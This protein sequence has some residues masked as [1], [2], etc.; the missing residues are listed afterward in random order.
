MGTVGLSFGS[1]FSGQGFNVSST[2]SEI[3]ANMSGVETPWTSQITTIG[4][5]DTVL[6]SLGTILS[7]LSTDMSSLTDVTGV[8]SQK[9]GS[10]SNTTALQLTA[11]DNTAV[12]G[13]H[14]VVINKLAT[15]SSGVLTEVSSASATLTGSIVIQVGSASAQTVTL[16]SSDN[17]LTGLATA[18]NTAGIGVTASVLTDSSG[19]RLSIV[20]GT[21]GLPGE[22]N[23]N[24]SISTAPATGSPV[25]LS[26][27]EAVPGADGSIVVD[28]VTL[29]TSSN[30]VNNLIPGVTFQLLA[31]TPADSNGNVSPVQV[32]IANYNSGVESTLNSLVTDYNSLISAINT[33]EGNDSSGNAEPLYGSP[34]LS[35]LQQDILNGMVN[36]NPN[37]Y[38]DAVS[39]SSYGQLSGSVVLQVGSGPGYTFVTGTGTNTTNTI[40]TGAGSSANTISGL[41]AAINANASKGVPL[42]ATVTA[43]S[44]STASGA[45]LTSID[46]LNDTL[47]GS[48]SIGVGGGTV[49]NVVIGYPPQIPAANTLYTNTGPMTAS[50]LATFISSNSLGV[51]AFVNDGSNGSGTLTLTSLTAGSAGT[52]TVNSGLSASGIGLSAGVVTS[53]GQST[54]TMVSDTAGASGVPTVTSSLTSL[55]P[56]TLS[57]VDNGTTAT[58]ASGSLGSV[59]NLTDH[60]SG[61]V[62]IQV[63]TAAPQTI[64]LSSN[65]TLQGLSDAIQHANLGVNAVVETV[66]GESSIQLYSTI[67]GTAGALTVTPSLVDLSN[68]LSTHVA[69]NFSSDLTSMT[70][71]GISVNNDG[72]LSLDAA[73]LDSV[74]NADFSGVQGLFQNA[75]SWGT[76]FASTLNNAGTSSPT[77]VLSLGLDSNSSIESTL[78]ADISRENLLISSQ[79]KSLTAELNSA[80]EVLQMIPSQLSQVNELYSAITGY[81]Q[82]SS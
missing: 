41:A 63:G 28:G 25:A 26:Y 77:G 52:L 66:G 16:K 64:T 15:T 37:G 34:T 38:L 69:Y 19:S 61:S 79:T 20:S 32:V 75:N 60:L 59:N 5:Q 80:N 12:A 49:Q 35:M 46:N 50:A 23:I 76:S 39:S 44:G 57:Y 33:Q 56:S 68:V 74:L 78:N 67:P 81:N 71:L 54:L 55:N 7:S 47:S 51:T 70:M 43:G 14:T 3:M 42:S 40:Y 18:I 9:E 1:P 58:E 30:T 53:N 6:S 17:T 22:L 82:S 73:S 62:V 45:T 21:S 2:V 13:N 27:H 36:K 29:S 72:T 65:N 48:I 24:S 8:L 11:A 31:T 4:S 10:S